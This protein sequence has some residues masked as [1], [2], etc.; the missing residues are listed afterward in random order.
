M[1]CMGVEMRTKVLSLLLIAASFIV[2]MTTPTLADTAQVTIQGP[3]VWGPYT[4]Q[5]IQNGVVKWQDTN[6]TLPGNYRTISAT[7]PSG[8]GYIAN[9]WL[10]SVGTQSHTWPTKCVSGTTHL[11]CLRFNSGG[12]PSPWQGSCP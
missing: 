9:V 10:N 6:V 8:C 2:G 5:F 3:S 1:I 4:V 11:G 12:E 7:V